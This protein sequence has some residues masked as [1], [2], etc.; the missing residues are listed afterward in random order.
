MDLEIENNPFFFK[1]SLEKNGINAI[2]KKYENTD[3]DLLYQLIETLNE[4]FSHEQS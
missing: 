3:N 4:E 2:L 1:K